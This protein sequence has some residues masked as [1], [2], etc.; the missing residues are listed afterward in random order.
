M[1]RMSKGTFAPAGGVTADPGLERWLGIVRLVDEAQVIAISGHTNPDGDALGSALG[2]GLSIRETCPGK[3]IVFLLAD[4]APVPRIYRFLPCADEFVPASEYAGTPDLFIAVDAPTLERLENAAAVALRA[5]ERAVIDH[6]P[7]AAEYTDAVVRDPEA[8]AAAV[9]V[10]DLLTRIGVTISPAVATCLFCGL[11]T[12]TGRFQY[13]SANPEAFAC[14][15]LLVDAGADPA[16]IALEVYQSQRIEFLRLE[17]LVVGRIRTAAQGRVAYSYAT[18]ADLQRYD[19]DFDECDGLIDLVRQVAGVEV[20]LFAREGRASG[21]VRG[22]LRSKYGHDVS[23]VA[24]RFNG[25]G[26]LAAAGFSFHG[27]VDEALSAVV[28][29]LVALVDEDPR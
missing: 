22:N 8:A 6:H 14:A 2:L 19:V 28:P 20:C 7:A 16:H 24:A 3:Q 1:M 27:S 17:A 21:V 10:S 15:A 25:G 12:D 29:E 13:Q 11:V 18:N 4:D 9:L 5:P 26:H 23:K